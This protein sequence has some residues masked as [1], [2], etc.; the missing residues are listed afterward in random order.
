MQL[1][2]LVMIIEL[3][4][5]GAVRAGSCMIWVVFCIREQI[6]LRRAYRSFSRLRVSCDGELR[7]LDRCGDW[8]A[9]RVLAGSVLLRH[10]GWIRIR[11]G[12]GSVFVEPLRGS[13]R[14]SADWR[15]LQVIWR[16]VGAVPVSC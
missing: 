15:R 1:A 4:V 8:Q 13:C 14:R 11:A 3:P 2:G 16:H 7:V 12:D 6:C 5:H 10:A 9:A